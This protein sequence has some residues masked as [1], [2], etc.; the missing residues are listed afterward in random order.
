M[1]LSNVIEKNEGLEIVLVKGVG[2]YDILVFYHFGVCDCGVLKN[3]FDILK[4]N[5]KL[6]VAIWYVK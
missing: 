2:D 3:I 6:E 1:R 5:T 4:T